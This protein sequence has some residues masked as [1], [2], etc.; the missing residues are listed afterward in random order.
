MARPR[1]RRRAPPGGVDRF[2]RARPP[3]GRRFRVADRRRGSLAA[4]A[5]GSWAVAAGPRAEVARSLAIRAAAEGGG[6]E[7]GLGE[8]AEGA[9]RGSEAPPPRVG[10]SASSQ[11]HRIEARRLIESSMTSPVTIIGPVSP[12]LECLAA[13]RRGTGCVCTRCAPSS[14][15]RRTRRTARGWCAELVCSDNPQCRRTLNAGKAGLARDPSARRR[16]FGGR[17][18]RR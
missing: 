8:A 15:P 11:W 9:G 1:P 14:R 12:V 16:L 5:S 4:P 13:C 6:G 17:R 7:A 2:V 10:A 18:A 3:P